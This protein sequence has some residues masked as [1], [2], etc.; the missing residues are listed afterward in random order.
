MWTL[1]FWKGA[2]ERA[3]KTFFQTAVAL[4]GVATTVEAVDWKV[5]VSGAGL[6]ALVSV[7]TSLANVDFVKGEPN[8]EVSIVTNGGEG[9]HQSLPDSLDGFPGSRS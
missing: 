9:G 8:V 3:I 7:F 2:S 5:V 4:I 6:A 1:S